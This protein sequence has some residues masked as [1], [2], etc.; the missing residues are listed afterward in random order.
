MAVFYAPETQM[1]KELRKWEYGNPADGYRG[2][3][4]Q[5]ITEYPKVLY[6]GGLTDDGV[7]AI[8]GTGTAGSKSEQA[9]LESQG[10][11]VDQADAL[12]KIEAQQREFA[13]LA[14]E[15]HYH[16]RHM[17][18]MAQREVAAHE[19]ETDQHLPSIPETPIKRRRGRPRKAEVADVGHE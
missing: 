7:I 17:S 1:A 9:R 13:K 18:P 4:E 19:A 2:Y 15:R 5:V 10:Y 12:R 8:I 11:T 6:L 14:A 16:E 3:R